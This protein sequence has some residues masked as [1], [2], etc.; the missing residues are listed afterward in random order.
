[1]L[2]IGQIQ[3]KSKNEK[4]RKIDM[5][6]MKS[7]K[8]KVSNFVAC[9]KKMHDTAKLGASSVRVLEEIGKVKKGGVTIEKTKTGENRL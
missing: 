5:S 4:R 8:K 7:K 2:N 6:N 1:M 9:L 3:P